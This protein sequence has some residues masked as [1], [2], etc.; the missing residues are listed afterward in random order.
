M[1]AFATLS[2]TTSPVKVILVG[3][4]GMGKHW[5][6]VITESVDAELV[7]IVDLNTDAAAAALDAAGLTGIPVGTSAAALAAETGAQAVINVTVPVAHHPVNVE[8]LFAGLPVLCEKPAAPTVAQAM[9]LAASAEA[10][11]QLLMISQSRRYFNTL[12]SFK[13]QVASLGDIGVVTT[14]FY[15]AA[16]FPGFREEMAHVLLVDMAIHAFDVSRYLLG[17]DPV[18]VYCEEFNPSWSWYQGDAAT[19]AVFELSGG[20]R[21]VFNG[22]W[23]SGGLET[24]WNGSWRASGVNGT[25]RWDGDNTPTLELEDGAEAV[26]AG[27]VPGDAPE[28][29]AG[30]LAEFISALRTGVVPSAEIHDNVFSLA[31]VEAAVTSADSKQRV[32]IDDVLD[33]AYRDAV[34]AERREDVAAVLASWS[35]P[36]AAL[37]RVPALGNA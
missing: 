8:A 29:I 11:G 28:E 32:S 17:Q 20:T 2:D 37:A 1:S 30:S 5:I 35:S 25:S 22:S 14:E 6:R 10:S 21:Y 18:A 13:K 12:T 27:S 33:A 3:A 4:G 24:S 23:V 26:I 34:A 19:V 7:G 31:M 16:H 36:R 15:K 9:S